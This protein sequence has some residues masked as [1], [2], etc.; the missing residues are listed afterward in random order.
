MDVNNFTNADNNTTEKSTVDVALSV[1]H[2]DI[3]GSFKASVTAPVRSLVELG[4]RD[5]AAAIKVDGPQSAEYGSARFWAQ[6]VGNAAGMLPWFVASHKI[7]GKAAS[8]G[9]AEVLEAAVSAKIAKAAAT[10]ALFGGL[11]TPTDLS[12]NSTSAE[13]ASARLS[14]AARSAA[15][16]MI[17]DGAGMAF[18]KGLRSNLLLDKIAVSSVSG[19]VGGLAE[20]QLH[21]LQQGHWATEKELAQSATTYA[22]LGGGMT[23]INA[24]PGFRE[25]KVKVQE[26]LKGLQTTPSIASEM[27]GLHDFTQVL[28]AH[29]SPAEVKAYV[30]GGH[31][32]M[33]VRST[34]A[35]PEVL[36]IEPTYGGPVT[37]HVVGIDLGGKGV[38]EATIFGAAGPARTA[39]DPSSPVI[40]EGMSVPIDAPRSNT[41]ADVHNDTNLKFHQ[42]RELAR[43]I[44]TN[45]DVGIR[46]STDATFAIDFSATGEVKSLCIPEGATPEQVSVALSTAS[47]AHLIA[48]DTAANIAASR[49]RKPGIGFTSTEVDAT[50]SWAETKQQAVR[51]SAA[52][53]E[54][55]PGNNYTKYLTERF[56]EFTAADRQLLPGIIDNAANPVVVPEMIAAGLPI[57]PA[58][59]A[60]QQNPS[61]ADM[62]PAARKAAVQ[63][64]L[65]AAMRDSAYTP[66]GEPI[67]DATMLGEIARAY[68]PEFVQTAIA[69]DTIT[70]GRDLS[71]VNVEVTST[72]AKDLG[73][74]PDVA[75][76]Q[77]ASNAGWAA[78]K[79]TDVPKVAGA[80]TLDQLKTAIDTHHSTHPDQAQL[81]YAEALAQGADRARQ[82]KQAGIPTRL[83]LDLGYNTGL[84]R[85]INE[86]VD[87][88]SPADVTTACKTYNSV[89]SKH[90]GG[91]A[92][93]LAVLDAVHRYGN[94]N[95]GQVPDAWTSHSILVADALATAGQKPT[96]PMVEVAG[97]FPRGV[98][99]PMSAKEAK[100]IAETTEAIRSY[101]L[102]ADAASAVRLL[103]ESGIP[104]SKTSVEIAARMRSEGGFSPEVCR[105]QLEVMDKFPQAVSSATVN[106]VVNQAV[107]AA[108]AES[109]LIADGKTTAVILTELNGHLGAG[110]ADL[111]VKSKVIAAHKK[112]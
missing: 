60:A 3:W 101:G 97:R 12:S 71:H 7:V 54:G 106:T 87:T 46:H 36:T 56:G 61:V 102:D 13:V 77:L 20:A 74:S 17:M 79:C 49:I 86:R 96:P 80:K 44:A 25:T 26:P 19:L 2:D 57:T 53:V 43:R 39:F 108:A 30:N 64:V 52:Y 111:I 109:G 34:T 24:L 69:I 15:T 37:E 35:I 6:Q 91:E 85:Y 110:V 45:S 18:N 66:N 41:F 62:R 84:N 42:P 107:Y 29:A 100:I 33:P 5:A 14:S 55:R 16:F 72:L 83:A 68:P 11:L 99:T 28:P 58:S 82:M 23:A 8:L 22:L 70:G 50:A 90:C 4:S 75:Y 93:T 104:T 10:G 95:A 21:A 27:A 81:A 65:R 48:N 78:Q 32:E 105:L 31:G 1:I 88:A 63:A 59:R 103:L 40:L 92:V 73:V 94:G 89:S 51:G 67:H 98:W 9:G 38:R 76:R 47:Y 112:D